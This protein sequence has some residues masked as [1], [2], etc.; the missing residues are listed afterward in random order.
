MYPKPGTSHTFISHIPPFNFMRRLLIL[1]YV[2][3]WAMKTCRGCHVP[4]NENTGKRECA[5][6]K[7]PLNLHRLTSEP[8]TDPKAPSSLVAASHTRNPQDQKG[9][10]CSSLW[11]LYQGLSS[12][13]WH[14]PSTYSNPLLGSILID[15]IPRDCQEQDNLGFKWLLWAFG[16]Q[17][18][19]FNLTSCMLG[20]A[21]PALL[22][23]R[24]SRREGGKGGRKQIKELLLA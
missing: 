7:Q 19:E 14:T 16:M 17:K 20:K 10:F 15:I 4:G 11:C 6:E 21:F 18:G 9:M 1:S 3:R 8:R 12:V 2:F 23:G 22:Q 5:G 13:F 24:W